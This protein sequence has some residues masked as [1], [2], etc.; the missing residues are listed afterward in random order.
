M[1]SIGEYHIM[2]NKAYTLVY[3]WKWKIETGSGLTIWQQEE[4]LYW[5]ITEEKEKRLR[6][7]E[8]TEEEKVKEVMKFSTAII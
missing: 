8:D 3:A 5:K 1:E 2:Y 4:G 6:K 7:K